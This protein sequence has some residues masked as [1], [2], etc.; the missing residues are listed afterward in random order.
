MSAGY[1]AKCG[2]KRR[3]ET[4]EEAELARRARVAQGVW[5]MNNTNS[6]RCNQCGFFHIGHVGR[7]FRGRR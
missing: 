1:L 3:H 4:R 2:N 6:Y 7:I 5:R